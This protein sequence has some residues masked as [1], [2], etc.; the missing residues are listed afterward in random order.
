[1]DITTSSMAE[2]CCSPDFLCRYFLCE[3]D[4][5]AGSSKLRLP[6]LC[7]SGR[8]RISTGTR[9]R[10]GVTPGRGFASKPAMNVD[11]WEPN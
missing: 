2:T 6:V 9:R 3:A 1:M 11:A 4:N 5:G 8:E 10:A 7:V